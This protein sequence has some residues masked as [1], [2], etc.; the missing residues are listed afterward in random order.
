MA[1]CPE[2]CS[3]T[4]RSF[5][6]GIAVGALIGATGLVKSKPPSPEG[7]TPVSVYQP[8]LRPEAL[9]AADAANHS[10]M[11]ATQP[12]RTEAHR[13]QPATAPAFEPRARAAR[14][15]VRPPAGSSTQ[16]AQQAPPAVR[17]AVPKASFTA[18]A[19]RS[20]DYTSLGT[21]GPLPSVVDIAAP[22]MARHVAQTRSYKG[23][24][25]M[26]TSDSQMGGWAYH[27]VHQMRRMGYEHWMILAD[28][29][30]TCDTLQEGW[31]PMMSGYQEELL[32]CTWS[33]Y[34][35][36]HPGWTQ[37]TDKRR[38]PDSMHNVYILWSTRWWVA[39]QL[40]QQG[41]NV[42]SLDVDAV[43]MTDIYALL[44]SPPLVHQDV[45]ITRNSDASQS[46]NCGF[47]YFNRQA[48]TGAPAMHQ[49]SAAK[50]CGAAHG[51][52]GAVPA[53][54]WVARAMWDRTQLFLEID[55]PSLSKSPAREVLWEQDAWNDLAK[56]LELNR[57][58]FPWAVG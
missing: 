25:I 48:R 11:A 8:Y 50:K 56:S 18:P 9:D 40:L 15:A 39:W 57:R 58:V 46:L 5:C 32:S 52:D 17:A 19:G 44:R 49:Q 4:C 7:A 42:L 54:E 29:A 12:T 47:V 14:A 1:P 23:E 53:A 16:P 3:S 35:R 22:G 37:W 41:T 38:G 24:L 30:K 10:A 6:I 45:I 51:A 34:P 27:W 21:I 26:F 43:L 55:R 13:Q 2:A 36:S 31:K 33:S 20:K 28:Q